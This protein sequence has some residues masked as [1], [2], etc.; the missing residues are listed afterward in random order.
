MRTAVLTPLVL[1]A[2]RLGDLFWSS[3]QVQIIRYA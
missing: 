2:V 3:Q 1:V